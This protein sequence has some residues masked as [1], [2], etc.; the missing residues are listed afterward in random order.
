MEQFYNFTTFTTCERMRWDRD[1][2][3]LENWNRSN[4][5]TT[6][7]S[8]INLSSV[9]FFKEF[10]EF[11]HPI[12]GWLAML[13][14]MVG[15]LFNLANILVLTHKDMRNPVNMILTGMA[16][17]DF[18]NNFE[19]I[20]FTAHMNLL[21]TEAR[22]IEDEY[23]LP[24]GIF[25]LFHTNFTLMIH[26]VAIW[27][28]LSL[29]IWRFIMIKFPSRATDLCT[30]ARCKMVLAFGYG[31]PFILT[32]P[33]TLFVKMSSSMKIKE[34][35]DS[36][37]T[38]YHLEI[39][40][41]G[42]D[43]GLHFSLTL[44]LYS[45][46]LKLVPC[47]VLTIFTACLVRAMYKAAAHS[48]KLRGVGGVQGGEGGGGGLGGGGKAGSRAKSTDKTT[49]LLIVILVLFL[50]AEFPQGILG[51][52][53]AIYGQQFFLECYTP[54]GEVMDLLALSNSA[55]NFLL[56]FAM[57]SQFR[58]TIRKML[59][60]PQNVSSGKKISVGAKKLERFPILKRDVV[61][62]VAE[63]PEH[64]EMKKIYSPDVGIMI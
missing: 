5:S 58:S 42:L 64:L 31:V 13:V 35:G 23:S 14:C 12:H 41:W 10:Q 32:V 33:N 28:T 21:D 49:K 57:S 16:V 25:M 63:S 62:N 19:Y 34:D 36:C 37:H 46:L 50:I 60:L 9:C 48:A 1:L 43:S 6:S 45:I 20:P 56:Y 11:Y 55:A 29:A 54:L 2:K 61:V 59:G 8:N 52:L 38:L 18:L 4:T 44:W 15:T 24:W 7:T 47:L 53:S 26:T 27:L 39:N 3:I 17:A 22:S 51:M 40:D 30:V